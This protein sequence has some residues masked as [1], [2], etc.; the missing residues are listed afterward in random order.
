MRNSSSP[1]TLPRWRW[2]VLFSSLTAFIGTVAIMLRGR[3]QP[4]VPAPFQ[5]ASVV[6]Y[7][8]AAIT[9][10]TKQAAAPRRSSPL[11]TLFF[12]AAVAAI[13]IGLM[14]IQSVDPD[15]AA[16]FYVL[17][18]LASILYVAFA[19]PH[20]LTQTTQA[21]AAVVIHPYAVMQRRAALYGWLMAA[22]AV[23][24]ALSSAALF[25]QARSYDGLNTHAFL[26]FIGCLLPLALSLSLRPSA[27]IPSLERLPLSQPLLRAGLRFSHVLTIAGIV[28]Y[29][30]L[31]EI[32]G[33]WLKTDFGD[34]VSS[35]IQF[36][37]LIVGSLFVALGLGGWGR[38]VNRSQQLTQPSGAGW[39]VRLLL[40]GIVALALLLRFWHL[41]DATRFLIDEDSFVVAMYDVSTYGVIGL[42]KPFSSIAAF[43]Y[44]FP[45]FQT[46]TQSLFGLNFLGLR[47]ASAILGAFGVLAL[48]FL[49]KS[50]FD[51]PTALLAALLLAT[52]PPHLQFSRIGISEIASPLFGTLSLAF[53]GRGLLH[54]RR[55]DFAFGGAMLGLTHYFHEG[56]RVLYTPLVFIWVILSILL[57]KW[58]A[59]PQP[60]TG[61]FDWLQQR[62]RPYLRHVVVAAVALLVVALPIYYTLIG[63]DR[64]I[65]ARLVSNTSALP[66]HYWQ[67]VFTN[68]SFSHHI[69][70]H[71]APAFLVYVNRPDSTLFYSGNTALVGTA[72]VP[73][74]LLGLGLA[75][76]RWRKPGFLL[77]L[78]WFLMTSFGNSFMVD[79]AGSP[80]FVMVLPALALLVA[81]AI[82]YITPLIVPRKSAQWLFMGAIGVALALFQADFYFNRHLPD[83]NHRFRTADEAPDGYDAAWRSLDFPPGTQIHLISDP[84]FNRIE[85]QG[86]INVFRKDLW[87]DTLTSK[88]FHRWYMS[89]LPCGVDHAF[90]IR[91]DDIQTLRRLNKYFSVEPFQ[92]S[93]DTDLPPREQFILYYSPHQPGDDSWFARQCANK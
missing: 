63:M 8:T 72:V 44:V 24:L 92:V 55:L 15:L 80:R 45:Y 89:H 47:A 54:N 83:Y 71:I 41:N 1:T 13:A 75:V 66:S 84:G 33:N 9:T 69:R 88:E 22:A 37:L 16:A 68:G 26:L 14:L 91:A 64:P 90:Y 86:L 17:L 12:V 30:L 29:A 20:Y 77:L 81:A 7:S 76:S 82:R 10:T 60:F 35:H 32:N 18:L 40:P 59:Q 23:G 42:L 46:L 2:F 56:G 93:P 58:P 52:F 38:G 3:K 73:V 34:S 70:D 25:W 49:A 85:A 6:D 27:A 43:P 19:A 67:Q 50:L 21:I 5:P 39:S 11:V 78:L 61:V 51:R 74:F 36:M 4:A 53:F 57:A 48:Y 28:I 87:L 65:F 62:Y 31:A 79:S